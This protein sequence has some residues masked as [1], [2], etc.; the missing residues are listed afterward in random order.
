MADDE[1]DPSVLCAR[2]SLTSADVAA[3]QRGYYRDGIV[4]ES[5]ADALFALE[6]SCHVQP[7]EWGPLF[8][9]AV[10]DYLVH[11]MQPQGYITVENATWLTERISVD[12]KIQTLNEFNLLVKVLEEARWAPAALATLALAQVRDAI[13]EGTGPLRLG[14]RRPAPGIANADDV[15]ALRRIL[16]ANAG[17]GNIAITRA[18]AEVLLDIGDAVDENLSDPSW[19]DL[20]TKAI[21]N[22]LMAGSGY[23]APSR[24]EV[25]RQDA[26]L[27]AEPDLGGFLGEMIH[28]GLGGIWASYHAPGAEDL[29]MAKVEEQRR[30]ILLNEEITAPEAGWLAERIGR[31]GRVS[32][33]E[34]ALLG[35]IKANSPRIDPALTPLLAMVA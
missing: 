27:T 15:A 34:R 13:V 9:M 23:V 26:W 25:L 35:F 24:Q 30:A 22:H 21:A 6:Q 7:P 2:G 1:I 14:P 3:I 12:G 28:S 4:A 5:E 31:D 29:A 10:T 20:F 19:A 17:E 8:S 16:Y 32:E 33:A 18:E 11:Q